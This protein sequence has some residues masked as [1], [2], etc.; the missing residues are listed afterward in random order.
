[1]PISANVND[2]LERALGVRVLR[3]E[4]VAELRSKARST[5]SA[6]EAVRRRDTEIERLKTQLAAKTAKPAKPSKPQLPADYEG[7]FAPIWESVRERTMTG[8]EKVYGLF[9]A[10]RY[11]AGHGIPGA[12]V[13]CGVWRGGSMLAVAQTL[14]R[15]G[16]GDR[17]LYLFDTY[18]GMTAPTDRDVHIARARSAREWLATADRGSWVRAIA[19]LEDVQQGFNEVSYPAERVHFVKGPVEE[20]VPEQAPEQI[21]ILRLDTDWYASTKHELEQLYHRLA[22]GGVLIIDDYGTWQGSKDAT[23]EFLAAT[24]EPLLL[25]RAG[26]G[27]IA[28]K[29]GLSLA[30]AESR[31]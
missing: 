29:P 22:P 16:I 30:G 20:T 10:V 17:D 24:G 31:R 3:S 26:Q 11:V 7:D 21:A 4:R 2:F 25:L 13:E 18:E 14:N 19:S 27:R 5:K 28:I 12:V 9:H 8:H 6:R 15:L 1:V 23:D